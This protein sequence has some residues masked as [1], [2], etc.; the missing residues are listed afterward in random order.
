MEVVGTLVVLSIAFYVLNGFLGIF[1]GPK[2]GAR[3][4]CAKC[5]CHAKHNNRSLK[6]WKGGLKRSICDTCHHIWIEE[7]KAA[8]A[9]AQRAKASS[10]W[11]GCLILV[12]LIVVAFAVFS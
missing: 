4:T 12:I 9:A 8:L 2:L 6:A 3:F 5:G 11:S 1:R 10:G 7:Q